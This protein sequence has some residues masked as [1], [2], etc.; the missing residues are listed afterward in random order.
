MYKKLL[1]ISFTFLS[2]MYL[3][4]LTYAD[5][6]FPV[7]LDELNSDIKDRLPSIDNN[8]YNLKDADTAASTISRSV[9]KYVKNLL[10]DVILVFPTTIAI[11]VFVYGGVMMV[12]KSNDESQRKKAI[13][14]IQYSVIGFTLII[15][16]YVIVKFIASIV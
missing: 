4:N 14:L 6:T 9:E 15:F 3:I 2:Y 5:V 10:E 13:E 11:C 16:S 8:E 1:L 7:I 12:L